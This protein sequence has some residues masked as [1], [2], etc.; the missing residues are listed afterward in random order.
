MLKEFHKRI[1]GN[2]CCMPPLVCSV[3]S[4]RFWCGKCGKNLEPLSEEQ[5]RFVH[6]CKSID[7]VI[8][9]ALG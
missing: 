5:L 7:E 2:C 9:G 3:L 1:V 8:L 6:G 4:N